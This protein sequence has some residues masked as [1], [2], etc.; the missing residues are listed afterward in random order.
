VLSACETGLGDSRARESVQGLV[1]SFRLAGAR[2]VIA[3]LWPVDDRTTRD[4]MAGVYRAR[5][6][7]GLDTAE[8][9]RAAS[10]GVIAG[11]RARG[12]STHPFYWAAFVPFGE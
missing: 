12:E 4:W 10:R 7:D 5:W 3:S 6:L 9:L 8:A 2:T 11:R 1:R